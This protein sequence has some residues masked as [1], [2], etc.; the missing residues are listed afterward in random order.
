MMRRYIVNYSEIRTQYISTT[1]DQNAGFLKVEA[2]STGLLLILFFEYLIT[3]FVEY[4]HKTLA[5]IK[6]REDYVPHRFETPR[7]FK[8]HH[9]VSSRTEAPLPSSKHHLT[10]ISI[11]ALIAA[12][13]KILYANC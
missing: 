8:F 4:A 7:M 1:H 6:I 3:A 13:A 9:L 12:T 11:M 10:L 2:G 5:N